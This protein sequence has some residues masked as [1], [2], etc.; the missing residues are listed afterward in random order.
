MEKPYVSTKPMKF[1]RFCLHKS[2]Y[3]LS[4]KKSSISVLFC[5][6]DLPDEWLIDVVEYKQSTQ[7]VTNTYMI[8]AKQLDFYIK[9]YE[10]DAFV[11]KQS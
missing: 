10:K 7:L 4:K 9:L 6:E 11:I 5:T 2:L 3:S 1:N 8:L